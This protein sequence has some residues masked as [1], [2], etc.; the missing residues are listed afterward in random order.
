LLYSSEA[1]N[2][3]VPYWLDMPWEKDLPDEE[4]EGLLVVPY[5]YDCNGTSF[6]SLSFKFS[7]ISHRWKISHVSWV[8]GDNICGPPKRY[9]RHVS[10]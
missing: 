6:P 9:I 2:D 7:L 1:F 8:H 10:A 5:N 4:K 3:D